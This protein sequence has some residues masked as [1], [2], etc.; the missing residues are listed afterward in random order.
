MGR[1]YRYCPGCKAH[2]YW[3]LMEI[4]LKDILY[5][6]GSI[7]GICAT[8]FRQVRRSDKISSRVTV[9]EKDISK[10]SDFFKKV[11]LDDN[12]EI[13]LVDK[14]AAKEEKK[15]LVAMILEGRQTTAD[16]SKKL[17]DMNENII[18]IMY[19]LNVDPDNKKIKGIR[20]EQG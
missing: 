17:T 6:S 14:K 3:W 2:F 12:G 15:E 5:I 16:V 13:R 19:H 8:Y 18:L 7:A 9:T 1:A 20:K 4:G 10:L 11:I